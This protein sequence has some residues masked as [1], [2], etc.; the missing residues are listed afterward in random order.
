[1]SR[2]KLSFDGR[3]SIMLLSFAFCKLHIAAKVNESSQQ[4]DVTSVPKMKK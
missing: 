1:M 4:R 3:Y 2:K